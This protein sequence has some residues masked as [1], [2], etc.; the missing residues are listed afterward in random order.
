MTEQIIQILER[1]GHER[2]WKVRTVIQIW[3]FDDFE[4]DRMRRFLE[5]DPEK[6]QDPRP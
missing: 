2:E 3:P 4:R 6:Q 5:E 1:K